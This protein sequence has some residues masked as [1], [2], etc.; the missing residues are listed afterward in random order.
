[1]HMTVSKYGLTNISS[2]AERCLSLSVEEYLLRLITR[3]RKM[4]KQRVVIEKTKHQIVITRDIRKEIAS[5]NQKAEEWDRRQ[6]EVAEEL[7]PQRKEKHDEVTAA[8]VAVRAAV[9][10]NDLASR[11]QL[12]YKEAQQKREGLGGSVP[13]NMHTHNFRMQE[14]HPNLE[15]TRRISLED[16][17]A[18]LETDPQMSKSPWIHRL[19]ERLWQSSEKQ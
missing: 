7:L 19:Y 13:R 16:L 15:E 2:E 9:G 12:M 3:A 10:G 5:I 14:E 18:A 6:A 8:N 17:I 1:M 11:W 4:S